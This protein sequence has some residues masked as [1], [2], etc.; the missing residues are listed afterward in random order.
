MRLTDLKMGESAAVLQ[1]HG[2]SAAAKRLMEM[3]VI[4]GVQVKVVKAAP[5]G[6]PI[7]VSVKGSHLAIRKSEAEL[8]E[9]AG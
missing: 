9:V 1:V 7:E 6:D 2:N 3:G 8:I 5:L 4:P